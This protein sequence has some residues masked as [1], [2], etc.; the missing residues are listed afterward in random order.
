MHAHRCK[1]CFKNGRSTLWAHGEEAKG[2]AD[3]HRCPVCG[4]LEWEKYMIAVAKLPNSNGVQ[5]KQLRTSETMASALLEFAVAFV[6]A[7]GVITIALEVYEYAKL[8]Q[9]KETK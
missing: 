5:Q 6:I 8:Y 9:G 1:V 4:N 2:S 7:Y 3:A